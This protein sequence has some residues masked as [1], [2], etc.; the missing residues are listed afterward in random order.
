MNLRRSL[1]RIVLLGLPLV[2]LLIGG[3]IVQ[4]V[5]PKTSALTRSESILIVQ[6]RPLTLPTELVVLCHTA[7]NLACTTPP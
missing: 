4:P 5:L 1:R 7:D 3:F 6:E 2:C